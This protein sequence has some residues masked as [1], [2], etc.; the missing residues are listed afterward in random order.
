M[1][2]KI[3]TYISTLIFLFGM[4]GFVL[5]ILISMD[6][7]SYMGELP[8]VRVQGIIEQ[9]NKLYIGLAE[10]NRIQVYDLNGHYER[11]FKV[12]NYAKDF[13]FTID[14][15]GIPSITVLYT[16][17]NTPTFFIQNNG[18]KYAIKSQLPLILE[19][20]DVFTV[21]Q[22]V[23][24]Q[25]WYWSLWAGSLHSWLLGLC[26]IIIFVIVN[27]QIIMELGGNNRSKE[28]N[29]KLFFKKVFIK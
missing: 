21:K 17:K 24:E 6:G 13:D 3:L 1:I 20:T 15:Y 28:E 18:N 26:G 12:E 19:R 23:I 7:C 9:E 27:I 25:P 11:Y 22:K 8:I 14:R 2:R 5:N 10:Y 16:R 29:V 4:L